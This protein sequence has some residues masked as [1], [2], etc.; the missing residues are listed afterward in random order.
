VQ[1]LVLKEMKQ[2]NVGR[3]SPQQIGMQMEI[4]YLWENG[5]HILGTVMQM[6][7]RHRFLTP[8]STL[9]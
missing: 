5:I 9:H 1:R 4:K 2:R 3:Q 8:L 7:K 6:R